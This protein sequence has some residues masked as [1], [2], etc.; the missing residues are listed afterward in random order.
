MQNLERPNLLNME[1]QI[2]SSVVQKTAKGDDFRRMTLSTMDRSQT[3]PVIMWKNDL[4]K[5]SQQSFFRTANVIRV[6]SY[7]EPSSGYPD[8]VLHDFVVVKEGKIGLSEEQR[9]SLYATLQNYIECITDPKLKK[10]VNSLMSDYGEAF[11]VS[12]AAVSMHHN[13]LGGLLEHTV[14]CL[15][16][17]KDFIDK[18]PQID[19]GTV[20]AACILHDFA[21]I[22]E[23]NID[24]E[25]GAITYNNAFIS[26]WVSHSQ[27]GYSM[28]MTAGFEV[29]AKMIATHHS[30]ADWGAVID[31]DTKDL[32]PIYYLLHHI[33]D[34]SAK[35]GKTTVLDI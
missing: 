34:L 31:L 6:S 8:Y 10:F 13:F 24:M 25:N 11:K 22:W 7:D 20:Y 32:E 30:R 4:R 29:V 15:D 14:E 21:K 5:F 17:A 12:P 3:F 23:Y 1:L 9:N 18:H 27:W 16:I 26:R 33:D 2:V 35:F 19:R 28:C